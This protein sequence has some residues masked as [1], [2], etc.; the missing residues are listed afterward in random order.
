MAK[1]SKSAA[2]AAAAA[3]SKS[4]HPRA[5]PAGGSQGSV[6]TVLGGVVAVL[7]V[8]AVYLNSDLLAT[9]AVGGGRAGEA[10]SS[11]SSKSATDARSE[12]SARSKT[13]GDDE[14]CKAEHRAAN[15]HFRA[16][17]IQHGL[18]ELMGCA[19]QHPDSA[20]CAHAAP[21]SSARL[22]SHS[23]PSTRVPL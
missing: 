13:E 3:S 10:D 5:G 16:G 18:E 14:E 12:G 9:T 1:S 11:A 6:I 19:K 8:A 2:A 4:R 7:A 20:R 23:F 21:I 17:R 15:V 22:A